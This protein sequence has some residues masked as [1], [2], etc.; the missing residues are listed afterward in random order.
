MAR[1]SSA[2]ITRTV[3]S[4]TRLM[5]SWPRNTA[6]TLAIIMPTVVPVITGSTLWKRAPRA[7]VA[8]WV[9]SPISTRKKAMVVAR[10]G[11]NRLGLA[12]S[13]SSKLSGISV[14]P[15]ITMKLA[16]TR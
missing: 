15:A 5:I 13:S 16:A 10:N 8:S 2:A 4:G 6:G 14:Q 12:S 1:N 7:I 9:L 3:A 11:P